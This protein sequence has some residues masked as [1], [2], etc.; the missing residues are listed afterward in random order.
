MGAVITASEPSWIVL[1]L[2]ASSPQA[3]IFN[4]HKRVLP[5]RCLERGDLPLADSLG[6]LPSTG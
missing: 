1:Y 6:G 4:T 2:N 5:F 3:V